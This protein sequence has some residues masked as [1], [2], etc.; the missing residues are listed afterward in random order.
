MASILFDRID[1][2]TKTFK[3]TV[4]DALLCSALES[5]GVV[6]HSE[7]DEMSLSFGNKSDFNAFYNVIAVC[8]SVKVVLRSS[9]LTMYLNW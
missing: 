6:L 8:P 5:G 4:G 3:K 7:D 9:F 1:D 2:A